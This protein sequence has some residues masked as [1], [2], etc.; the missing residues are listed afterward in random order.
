[1]EDDD[2]SALLPDAPP[3]RP[4]RRDQAIDRAMRRFDG[5]DD[6]AEVP[7][8]ADRERKRWW[9]APGRRPQWGAVLTVA[10]VAMIALPVWVS[11]DQRPDPAVRAVTSI[12]LPSSAVAPVPPASAPMDV[13]AASG[14]P[15]ETAPEQAHAPREPAPDRAIREEAPPPPMASRLDMAPIIAPAP[16]PPPPAPIVLAAPPAASAMARTN[17]A[18]AE[19]EAQ[20]ADNSSVVVTGR[21]VRA[22]RRAPRAQ[23]RPS[24]GRGDWNACT[25]DDPARDPSLCAARARAKGAPGR[26]D[27]VTQGLAHAWREDV[28]GAIAQFDA[29]IAAAPRSGAAYLNRGLARA[30]KGETDRAL[31]DLDRAVRLTPN[32]AR[33]YYNRSVLLRRLG[34]ADRANADAA[35]ALALDPR[36]GEVVR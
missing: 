34:D 26:E 8:R 7:A 31:A 29:A 5:E 15:A 24:S 22:E 30:R 32:S 1:M 9:A 4:D 2:L 36:Y 21:A 14:L 27:H 25:I 18:A 6:P 11:R 28:D 10:L 17:K 12:D 33:A 19:A 20:D 23:A 16:P 3:P 35:R 13:D